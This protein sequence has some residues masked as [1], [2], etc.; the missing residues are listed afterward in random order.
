M[1][2]FWFG[3]NMPSF[4]VCRRQP[5]EGGPIRSSSSPW[6]QIFVLTPCEL[7]LN[8]CNII[9][10]LGGIRTWILISIFVW[11]SFVAKTKNANLSSLLFSVKR[12]CFVCTN[13]FYFS[14]SCVRWQ[15]NHT[16][17]KQHTYT[18]YIASVIQRQF[19]IKANNQSKT[20]IQLHRVLELTFKQKIDML[21]FLQQKYQ[22]HCSLVGTWLNILKRQW[23]GHTS[24]CNDIYLKMTDIR[25]RLMS[26]IEEKTI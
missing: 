8:I 14:V 15:Q 10:I 19:Q 18:V 4:Q 21:V 7:E 13:V 11:A 6:L 5:L 17:T 20:F 22:I 3:K 23:Y 9:L 1:L 2:F 16:I 24:I 26:K 12:I 25:I